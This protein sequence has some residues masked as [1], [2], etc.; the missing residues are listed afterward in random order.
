[1]GTKEVRRGVF[2]LLALACMPIATEAA[3]AVPPAKS[4]RG[5][6]LTT[7]FVEVLVE[8]IPI[9]SRYVLEA[10]PVTVRNNSDRTITMRYNSLE[11]QPGEMR[12]SYDPIPSAGW[13]QFE[14]NVSEVRPGE[15]SVGKMVI[16]V[17][18]DPALVGK[19]FQVAVT[20]RADPAPGSNLAFGLR[21]RVMFSV[22]GKKPKDGPEVISN[23]VPLARILPYETGGDRG[24][25][26]V[27]CGTLKAENNFKEEMVYEVVKDPEAIKR[28]TVRSDETPL[29]DLEWLEVS[30]PVMV[31]QGMARAEMAL[32]ARLPIAEE[33]FGKMYVVALRTVARRKGQKPVDVYNKVRIIVPKLPT[34]GRTDTGKPATK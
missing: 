23:P 10:K 19:R 11:P 34:L 13:V 18:D 7:D 6:A 32:T 17:P 5:G 29:P 31:L 1:M 25:I 26:V 28:I 8:G 15:A 21:P 22:A 27:S 9:G 12:P 4:G 14:P 20:L 33:H 2:A 3:S 16:Y 30:P 24:S